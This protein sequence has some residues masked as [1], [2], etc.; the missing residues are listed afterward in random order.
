MSSEKYYINTEAGLR[1]KS[2][3]LYFNGGS[4]W[5]EHLDG[6]GDMKDKVIEKFLSDKKS[7]CR[8]SMTSFVIVNLDQTEIDDDIISCI[9][10]TFVNSQKRF[11]KIA[12]VG[13]KKI[14]DR[15]YLRDISRKKGCPVEFF[16]DF[17][18]AK[19]WV[20]P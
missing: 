7:F 19:Q 13:I 2:F 1:K 5:A 8:P 3:E 15:N 14:G 17:E 18:K 9:Y 10:D 16:D 4:I 20:L 12:F 6:M 11:M